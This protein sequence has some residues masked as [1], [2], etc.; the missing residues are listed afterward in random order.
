[1]S[2][3]RPALLLPSHE[4][5]S[6]PATGRPADLGIKIQGEKRVAIIP[7]AGDRTEPHSGP[8]HP[9]GDLPGLQADPLALGAPG[10]VW[11]T[12]QP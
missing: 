7:A 5:V 4:Q 11:T 10:S 12:E 6:A 2:G 9:T 8:R 1:M 3:A